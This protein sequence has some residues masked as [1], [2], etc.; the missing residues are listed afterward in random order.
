[1]LA[2]DLGTSHLIGNV[3]EDEMACQAFG[4]RGGANKQLS[5]ETQLADRHL[6]RE[7]AYPYIPFYCIHTY[8]AV[9]LSFS[10]EQLEK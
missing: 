5:P 6:R 9:R 3:D 2:Q 8:S 10:R 4:W 7:S 1:M